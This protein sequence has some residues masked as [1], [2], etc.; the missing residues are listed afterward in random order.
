MRNPAALIKSEEGSVMVVA[1]IVLAMLTIIG[2]SASN[3]STTELQ[4]VRN[5]LLYRINFYKAEAAA[6]EGAQTVANLAKTS[7]TEVNP[8]QTT[9]SWL[10]DPVTDGIDMTAIAALQAI[11]EPSSV[12]TDGATTYAAAYLGRTGSVAAENESQV[13]HFNLYGLHADDDG[14]ALI[15]MGYKVKVFQN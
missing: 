12:V 9:K 13:Y 4:I 14:R 3:T 10:L 11:D 15:E 1:L 5:D 6:R 2:I 7:P 8:G